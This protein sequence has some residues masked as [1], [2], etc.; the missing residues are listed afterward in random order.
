MEIDGKIVARELRA[1]RIKNN[2]KAEEVC[3]NVSIER[4]S[5]YKYEKDA[6]DLKYR[7]LVEMLKLYKMTPAIFF[8]M[9]S[10]YNH[11]EEK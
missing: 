6:S 4:T 1:L 2:L 11:I 8:R 9:I 5:L 10:E 3:K 7:I